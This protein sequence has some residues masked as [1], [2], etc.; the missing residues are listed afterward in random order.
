MRP[1]CTSGP[2]AGGHCTGVSQH[3]VDIATLAR[4]DDPPRHPD[5]HRRNR[6]LEWCTHRPDVLDFE[7]EQRGVVA[8]HAVGA[9]R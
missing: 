8:Q 9:G 1:G 6:S 4:Y 7:A 3:Y 5:N 2:V